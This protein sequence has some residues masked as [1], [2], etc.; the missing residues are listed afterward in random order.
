MNPRKI[1]QLCQHLREEIHGQADYFTALWPG[2]EDADNPESPH[3]QRTAVNR[4]MGYA[5]FLGMPTGRKDREAEALHTLRSW[6]KQLGPLR[7]IDVIR[8]WIPKCQQAGP[9]PGAAQPAVDA[10]QEVLAEE[11]RAILETVR[12]DARGLPGART[13]AALPTVVAR[14]EETLL[15]IEETPTLFDANRAIRQVALPWRKRLNLLH[16]DQCDVLIHSFRVTNKRLRFVLELLSRTE[17]KRTPWGKHL[18]ASARTALATHNTLGS[19]SDLLMVNERLRLQRSRW[20]IAAAGLDESA[21]VLERGRL[22]LDA[23]HLDDW[24]AHWPQLVGEDFI[25]L[26]Q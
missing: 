13:R 18:A 5:L 19:L 15:A 26:R 8:Q 23:G 11:R 9:D 1:R 16:D 3:R 21:A 7:D 6:Q 2:Y 10:F 20:Q 4:M 17:G 24:F 22:A 14:F 12:L 25:P